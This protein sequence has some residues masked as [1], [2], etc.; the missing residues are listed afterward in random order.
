MNKI[1]QAYKTNT[2]AHLIENFKLL[3]RNCI[4]GIFIK[5]IK[6]SSLFLC[7]AHGVTLY[8]RR[9]GD[10]LGG[11]LAILSLLIPSKSVLNARINT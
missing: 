10:R 11:P 7:S 6:Y 8:E 1:M 4:L 9:V 2:R 5:L 3:C